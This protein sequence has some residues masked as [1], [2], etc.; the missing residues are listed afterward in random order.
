MATAIENQFENFRTRLRGSQVGHF[1]RWWLGEL[2][3]ALP[4]GLKAKMEHARRKVLL[5]LDSNELG[6]GIHETGSMQQIEVLP[7]GKDSRVQ[8]QQVHDLLVDRELSEVPRDLHLPESR[9]LH[10]EVFLPLA[11]EANLRQALAFEMDRQTPFHAKDVFFDYK[12]IQRDREAAQVRVDLFVTLKGPVLKEIEVLGPLG[13]SPS[14]VDVEIDGSPAGLNLL[15]PDLRHRIVNSRMRTNWILGAALALLLIFVMLQSLWLRQHQVNEVQAATD[16]VRSEA[17]QVQQ[18]RD[19]ISDA[20]EAAGFM[21]GQ[22]SGS[23]PTVKVLTEVTRVLPDD[24]YLDRLLIGS[25]SVQ[26]QGKSENAQ[27]L[28]ETLNSS[29]YFQNAS[30]RGPTRLDTRTQKEIFDVSAMMVIE[31]EG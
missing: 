19:R 8:R 25:D 23:L 16:E 7:I 10:K 2:G 13:L 11:A 22:R 14:G 1:V 24:T 31:G 3:E 27:Q 18:L 29:P 12:V 20:T 9:V 26:M 6:I 28:I 5:T 21:Q 30:F 4:P 17:M 15:P